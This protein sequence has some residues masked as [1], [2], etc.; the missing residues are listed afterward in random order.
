M[1]CPSCGQTLDPTATA[2]DA[3]GTQLPSREVA[4]ATGGERG[5]GLDAPGLECEGCGA[6]TVL[7]ANERIQEC[8]YCG[9]QKVLEVSAAQAADVL[10]P[11]RVI[12]FAFPTER[13]GELFR[14]WVGSL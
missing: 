14:D 10:Q 1:E 4:P 2:C 9:S 5:W 6:Q 7:S 3:C 12:R 8:P 11:E 13:S